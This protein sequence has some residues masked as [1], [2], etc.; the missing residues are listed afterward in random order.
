MPDG[1]IQKKVNRQEFE[2]YQRHGAIF[3]GITPQCLDSEMKDGQFFITLEN[4]GGSMGAKTRR[5]DFKIGFSSFSPWEL[6]YQQG[7]SG[8]KVQRKIE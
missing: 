8:E 4:I 3:A 7:V 1:S 2:F 6:E 5:A